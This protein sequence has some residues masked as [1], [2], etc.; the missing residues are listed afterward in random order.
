MAVPETLEQFCSIP[1]QTTLCHILML[2]KCVIRHIGRG[3][4]RAKA[5][6]FNTLTGRPRRC[7][8]GEWSSLWEEARS[9]A[10]ALQKKTKKGVAA[11]DEPEKV[12]GRASRRVLCLL[13]NKGL[14]KAAREMCASGA[15]LHAI[16]SMALG[17]EFSPAVF[18][19]C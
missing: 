12:V 9:A 16:P 4:A 11:S 1:S 19:H 8:N 17:L 14:S 15:W 3:G 13:A 7:Q 6:T 5:Q 18:A 2:P 10:E